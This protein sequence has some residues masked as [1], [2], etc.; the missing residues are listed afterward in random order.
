MEIAAVDAV[1]YLNKTGKSASSENV[2]AILMKIFSRLLNRRAIKARRLEGVGRQIDDMVLVPS[3]ENNLHTLLFL[4]KLQS[5]LSPKSV[6]ILSQRING[7]TWEEIAEMMRSTKA[8]LKGSFWREIENAKLKLRIEEQN[9][10]RAK[11]GAGSKQKPSSV[12]SKSGRGR[13]P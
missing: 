12:R 4:E 9:Q 8:V 5:C 10:D 1:R 3:W 2:E 13:T 11:H 6:T 7:H